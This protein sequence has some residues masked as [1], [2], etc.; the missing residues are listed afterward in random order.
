MLRSLVGSEMCIRDRQ[1]TEPWFVLVGGEAMETQGG[2][3]SKRELMHTSLS[4][5]AEAYNSLRSVGVPRSN[6]VTVVQLEDFM[7]T[8][9]PGEYCH[10]YY[11]GVCAKMMEE[12]GADYDFEMVA[13]STVWAILSGNQYGGRYPKVLPPDAH[14]V[15]FCVYSHGDSHSSLKHTSPAAQPRGPANPMDVVAVP[16]ELDPSKT[17]W[18]AHFPY[19]SPEEMRRPMLE[20]VSTDGCPKGDGAYYLYASQLKSLFSQ[21]FQQIP[22]RPV[23]ALL[24]YCRSG[25]ALAFM[26]NDTIRRAY[27]ADRWPLFLM[28]SS[29]PHHDALV[30]GLWNSFFDMLVATMLRKDL[31]ETTL[32]ELYETAQERYLKENVYELRDHVQ[33]L[34]YPSNFGA[35]EE[36]FITDLTLSLIH[37]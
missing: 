12:G 16:S 33:V 36:S 3:P 20:F 15:F 35:P 32:I 4:F 8:T 2:D 30:G 10:Q 22:T 25:G 14:S 37:I 11:S 21:M 28:S 7:R 17:E 5:I 26:K 13:P 24:N 23:V 29:Q 34:C 18:Y 9:T 1:H 31:S 19:P 6:I 27:G